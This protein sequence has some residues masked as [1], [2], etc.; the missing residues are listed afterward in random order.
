M[1]LNWSRKPT[2][3][4]ENVHVVVNT[5]V[6]GVSYIITVLPNT[7]TG[8]RKSKCCILQSTSS[9]IWFYLGLHEYKSLF[10]RNKYGKWRIKIMTQEPAHLLGVNVLTNVSNLLINLLFQLLSFMQLSVGLL[11]LRLFSLQQILAHNPFKNKQIKMIRANL[12]K[13]Y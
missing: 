11:K 10:S 2:Q 12:L 13:Y 5:L 3:S 8:H 1:C 7:V 9:M 6:Y 4:Q